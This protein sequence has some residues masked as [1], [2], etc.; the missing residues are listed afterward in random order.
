MGFLELYSYAA[1]TVLLVVSVLWMV[2]VAVRDASIID[3]FWGLL[4]VA[5]A[6]TLFGLQLGSTAL[7]PFVFLFLVTA[8]GMR[9]AVHLA[10]RNLGEG[11]DT[12]Y[13]VWRSH[14]GENWWLKTYWRIYLLQGALALI[15]ATPVIAAFAGPD[16]ISIVNWLGVLV[17][18]VGLGME[19]AADIQLTRFRA[20][21][22][23]EEKV[24]GSGLWRYSRHPNYFGDALMWWGLGLFTLS[25]L[26]WW[27]LIGPL[28][29]TVI[30]LT[31]SN[32]VI[33]RGLK[34]RRP[35][36]EAYVART[37]AFLPMPPKGGDPGADED[38]YRPF[39]GTEG[40]NRDADDHPENP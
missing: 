19:S 23:N 20:D 32:N 11:E 8:W 40:S 26:T 18:G 4:F 21:P 28:A 22:A 3:V 17:W 39:P 33:E 38:Q 27:S 15:V 24:M 9:L 31:L 6:W 13:R 29:M 36:Y 10:A 14:G 30:F 1:L 7:K 35:G 16:R 25:P 37:S 5:V 34:K 12:R 2:S